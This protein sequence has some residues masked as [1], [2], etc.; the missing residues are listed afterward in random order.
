M[1]DYT[2]TISDCPVQWC[3][4]LLWIV[5]APIAGA[6]QTPQGAMLIVQQFQQFSGTVGN[7]PVTDGKINGEQVT[8]VLDGNRVTAVARGNVLEGTIDGGGKT[9]SWRATRTAK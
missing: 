2:E 6:W 9:T 4:V 5:P 8:F 1:P 3:T 7:T